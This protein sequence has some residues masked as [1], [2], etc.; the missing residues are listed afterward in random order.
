[1]S[2]YL[3]RTMN[4]ADYGLGDVTIDCD[5]M[6]ILDEG[7]L[8][9]RIVRVFESKGYQ[10]PRLPAVA[11]ELL[12]LSNRSDVEFSAVEA[13]LEKDAMLAG[14][15]LSLCKSAAYDRGGH[16][17][18]LREALVRI[19]LAKLR[20]IVMQA[21]L[22]ARV[23]RASA[24]KGCMEA[25]QRHCRVTAHLARIV[26][27][28]TPLDEERAFLC[29]LLHDVGFAGILIVLSDTK[30]GEQP[31][32]LDLLWPS[33]HGAHSIAGCRMVELWDLPS[34][35]A[36]AVTAHH[37]VSIDGYDHPLAS[38]VCL[39]E[40]L[41]TELGK[42]FVP[43]ARD[44]AS[45]STLSELSL[46]ESVHVDQSDDRTVQRAL[47]AVGLDAKAWDQVQA[48]AQAWLERA[49]AD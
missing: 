8:T 36:L 14:E 46:A 34:E 17:N 18:S 9:E 37:N 40:T 15:V 26:S 39:A 28:A 11:T 48:A 1:M 5:E 32:K 10:P 33:I 13:L 41:A 21:A 20:E 31:P 6:G 2:A 44:A 23:F 38:I 12:A 47:S 29:G 19:G 22:S 42:G 49:E 16:I 30:R 45:Q 24:Y 3:G 25:L 4:D 35:I 7:A 43:P 27:Q